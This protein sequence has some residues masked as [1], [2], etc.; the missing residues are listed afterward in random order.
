MERNMFEK[1]SKKEIR[2]Q[3][4]KEN[5]EGASRNKNINLLMYW[6]VIYDFSEISNNI[7]KRGL[8]VWNAWKFTDTH[9]HTP[10]CL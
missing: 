8:T 7:T 10:A 9:S 2:S 5:W 6:S 3:W 4:N 1:K